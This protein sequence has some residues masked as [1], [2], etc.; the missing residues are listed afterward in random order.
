MRRHVIIGRFGPGDRGRIPLGEGETATRLDIVSGERRLDHGIG[1]ALEDLARLGVR[2]TEIGLDLLILAAHVHAADTRVS[3][4]SESQDGWTRE[5]RLVVPVSDP[6]RWTATAPV[7]VQMLNFLTGDRWTVGFRARPARFAVLAPQRPAQLIG[8]PFDTLALFSGG[9]DSLINAIDRLQAGRVPLFVSHA[10]EGATSEA[11][12]SLF[13]A[14]KRHYPG[15]PFDRLRLWMAFPDGLVEGSAIE[16]TTRGR[17]FLFFALGIFAGSG[18]EGD[19]TLMAPENGL[20][21]INVPLDPLRLGA[22]S[23]RT[24]HPFYIARWNELLNQL[25]I[26]GR[27]DNPYWNQTKGEMTAACADRALLLRLTQSSLSCSS[28]SK[29][30]WKRIGT[31]HCGYCL[32]CLI[33]RA[34][35]D[36]GFGRGADP[37]TY[38]LANLTAR[39]LDTRRSEGQQIRSFQL[40]IERLRLRPS[41]AS[42]LI[43]KPGPLSDEP[44]A[45]QA[46]LAEFIGVGLRRSAPSLSA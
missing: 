10:G 24:T 6:D 46:A 13:E 20:I 2:P 25:A 23:T 22:L 26:P 14:L 18:L 30:R 8:P 31:Q 7:L 16:N 39:P 15:R 27:V 37:T 43:H 34:A 28:P 40:A 19:F 9:L 44:P 1:R 33:R 21:A 35:L 36:T 29:G 12:T 5:L 41:L 11:Q 4:D 32:P 45:R 38:T 42:I 17:S 3:R